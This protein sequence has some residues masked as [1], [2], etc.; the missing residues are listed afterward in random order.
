MRSTSGFGLLCVVALLAVAPAG[1]AQTLRTVPLEHWAYEIADQIL[2]RNPELGDGLKLSVGPWR[3]AD[4]RL[5][6][7]RAREQAAGQEGTLA[8]FTDLLAEAFPEP[9]TTGATGDAVILNEVSVRGEAFAAKEDAT[10][11]PAFLPPR[12]GD[13]EPEGGGDA[14]GRPPARAIAQHDFAFEYQDRFGLG[15]RYALDSNVKSDPTRFRQLEARSGSDVGFALLDAYG[16]VHYG[17]FFLTLG[18][19]ELSLGPGR[20]SSPFLSD[21]FPPLDQLR[22]EF[23]SRPVRFTGLIAR[24]SSDRQNRSLDDNGET[25]PGSQPPDGDR[26][27]VDRQLYLHR[28]DWQVHPRLQLAVTEAAL[29]TGIDRGLEVRYANLLVPFFVSQEDEDEE[30]DLNVNVVVDL[31]G[32]ASLPGGL[33]VYGL[34]MAQEFFVDQEKRE[35]IGNQLAWRIGGQWGSPP[36]MPA[37]TAG[38]EYTRVDVFTYLHRGLNTNWTNYGVPLGSSLGPDA[39][40]G[41]G[42]LSWYPRPTIRLTAEA[43][44]RRGGERSVETLESATEAGNPDTPS[45]IVQR[46]LL[47]ALEGWMLL[48]DFGVEALGRVGFRDVENVGNA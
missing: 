43:L 14:R 44:A 41:V 33:R 10:F 2:I 42:W 15:W 32:T 34:V 36:G 23:H 37:I 3:E 45:G 28:V 9:V 12:F 5:L 40:Q 6:L 22:V 11:D 30:E 27:R 38:A 25:I 39:D 48:P 29:V 31:E 18:R 35:E 26:R 20:G 17:P 7:E 24:L 1:Y 46:E 8:A 19:N 16:T 4:F 47:G 13:E 21:S